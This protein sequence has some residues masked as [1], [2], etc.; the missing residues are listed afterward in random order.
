[1]SNLGDEATPGQIAKWRMRNLSTI[2]HFLARMQQ[3]DL[4]DTRRYAG[5][6][7]RSQVRLTPKGGEL[8]EQATRAESIVQIFAAIPE[9]ELALFRKHLR[10]IRARAIGEL[11]LRE[12]RNIHDLVLRY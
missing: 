1:M 10:A 6:G 11:D 5:G 2:S 7:K 12:R 8:L 9:A 4:V 3:Q